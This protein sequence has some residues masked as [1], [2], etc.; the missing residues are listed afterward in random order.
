MPAGKEHMFAKINCA[1]L[2]GIHG[3][4]TEVEADAQNGIPGLFLT[5]ALSQETSEARFRVWNAIRNCGMD[6]RPKKLTVN[7]SPASLRKEGTAY[8][9]SIAM[10][11]L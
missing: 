10:A 2:S 7:I 3:F 6:I 5:G 4:M 8:D 9:L 11:I 1:G